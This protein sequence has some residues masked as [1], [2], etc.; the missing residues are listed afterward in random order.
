MAVI[1]VGIKD[2]IIAIASSTGG[3]EA[4]DTVIKGLPANTPPIL[5]VQHMPAILTAQFA[6]RLDRV[7]QISAKE[8]EDGD[9][10]QRNWA[11]VAPGNFHMKVEKDG[12]RLMVRCFQSAKMHGVRPAADI[13]FDSLAELGIKNVVGV[14]L[15]G[16]GADGAAGLKKLRDMGAVTIGQDKKSSVVY[17]M[18]KAAFDAG[19]VDFQLP[20]D[21]IAEKIVQLI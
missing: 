17:G 3:P 6:A 4:V 5:I 8:A 15:T 9:F 12:H 18:P 16:M 11:L 1:H 2:K 10:L 14:V 20:L 21:R 7:G 19:A 13:L